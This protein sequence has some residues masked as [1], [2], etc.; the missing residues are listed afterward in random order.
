MSN[1]TSRKTLLP[2]SSQQWT[3]SL[4]CLGHK[5]RSHPSTCQWKGSYL[6]HIPII[7]SEN[8]CSASAPVNTK[9]TT[10][11]LVSVTF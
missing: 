8:Y 2:G 10:H 4:S 9:E 5:L 6:Q 3:A 11:L 1:M 7:Q